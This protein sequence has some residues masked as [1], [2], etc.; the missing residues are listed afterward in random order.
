MPKSEPFERYADRYDDWFE[1]HPDAYQSEVEALRRLLPQPGFG[2]EIGVGTGRFASPLGI[3]V[4]ID[5]ASDDDRRDLYPSPIEASSR[6]VE[7]PLQHRLG[8]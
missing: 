5:P 6:D 1:A 4:G 2:L 7:I 3:Q 8:Q